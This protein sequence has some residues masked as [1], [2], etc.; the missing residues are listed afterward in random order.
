MDA[1]API[2]HGSGGRRSALRGYVPVVG[3]N[4]PC[5]AAPTVNLAL[6]SAAI[7]G[8]QIGIV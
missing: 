5:L 8:P 6:T 7:G 4:W 3:S 1:W 2:I